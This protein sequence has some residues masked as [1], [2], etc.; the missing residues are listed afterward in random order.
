M[1][2]STADQCAALQQIYKGSNTLQ[3]RHLG[4]DGLQLIFE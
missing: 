4:V 3:L 1:L 2:L